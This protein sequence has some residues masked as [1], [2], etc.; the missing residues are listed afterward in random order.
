MTAVANAVWT[1]AEFNTHVRDN[2][3][4]TEANK[5]A[6]A[7]G[8]FIATG[9]NAIAERNYG[10]HTVDAVG[11]RATTTYGDA[12][13]GDLTVGPTVTVTTGTMALVIVTAAIGSSTTTGGAL[14][15]FAVSGASTVAAAD[16][17]AI[18][19]AEQE[20]ASSWFS[21]SRYTMLTSLTAGSNTFTMK[22]RTVSAGTA[23]FF[24]R[25]ISVIA[26]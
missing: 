25:T 6:T 11:T 3:L 16:Q 20:D 9:A 8:M 12:T 22:Y 18:G 2:L 1:A 15:S 4:E 21:A 19:E 26:F 13:A 17:Y 14:A 5:A 23:S 24:W 10:K 7:G